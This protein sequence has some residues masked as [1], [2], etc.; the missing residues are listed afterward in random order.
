MN[1]RHCLF[2]AP[3]LLLVAACTFDDKGQLPPQENSAAVGPVTPLPEGRPTLAPLVSRAMPAV[4]SIA[5]LQP[6]PL[7]QNPLLRDPYF[8]RFFDLPESSR[9]PRIAAGSGVIVD[10]RRGLVLTNHHVVEKAQAIEVLLPDR[11]RFQAELLGSDKASDVAL[12]Q[13]DGKNLPELKLGDSDQLHIGDYVFAIGNPYGLGQSVTYGIVSALGRG[14]REDGYESYIQTDAPIN[15]GNSG[16]P[17]VAANTGKLIGLNSALFG[18]GA[19]VGI[20]FAVPSR[21]AE[22]V[23][24]QILE[25]GEVRRGQIGVVIT[26]TLPPPG[27]GRVPAEGALIADVER[28]SSAAAAGLRRGDIILAVNG[29]PTPTASNL[30]N[31]VGRTEIGDQMTLTLLRGDERRKATVQVRQ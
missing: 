22:F 26:D 24:D 8:R 29:R 28:G 9:E 2:L 11:R 5:V 1:A 25:H 27:G 21:T 13:I 30:R 15:P 12:L 3:W 31:M 20:G 23:M 10:S 16:G 4:V 19:N 17:L 18:P 7:Q 6:A 14:L